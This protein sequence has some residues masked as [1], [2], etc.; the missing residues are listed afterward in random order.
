MALDLNE[1]QKKIAK[2]IEIHVHP[3][4][5]N[6]VK[7]IIEVYVGDEPV[8]SWDDNNVPKDKELFLKGV[9][10]GIKATLLFKGKKEEK[11][12]L[13]MVDRWDAEKF[14]QEKGSSNHPHIQESITGK[15]DYEV[16]DLMAE[17][18]NRII[19]KLIDKKLF[20]QGDGN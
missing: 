2:L 9:K 10:A 20:E 3:N 19:K 17:F 8:F 14:L 13:L 7:D 6:L 5:D 12:D 4:I 1:L 15:I 18:A 11:S 16:A